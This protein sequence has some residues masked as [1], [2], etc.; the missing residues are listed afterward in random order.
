MSSQ[1]LEMRNINPSFRLLASDRERIEETSDV[2]R[3]SAVEASLY[4]SALVVCRELGLIARPPRDP[5]DHS[6]D[7]IGGDR[8]MSVTSASG[9]SD[10]ADLTP[11]A[12]F[13]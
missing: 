8:T 9:I 11:T 13:C 4:A 12:S 6:W 5:H 1:G 10:T 2:W 3:L 7:T